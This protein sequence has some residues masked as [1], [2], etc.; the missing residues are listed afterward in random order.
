MT[1]PLEDVS[2]K[3][4]FGGYGFFHAGKMFTSITSDAELFLKVGD[5][6]RIQ[7]QRARAPQHGKMLY[8]QVPTL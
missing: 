8:F 1:I 7:F 3:K 2:S 5:T 4:V 6:N